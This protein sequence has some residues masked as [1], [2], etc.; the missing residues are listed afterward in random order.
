MRGLEADVSLPVVRDFINRVKERSKGAEVSGA[1]NPAQQVVKIVNDELTRT[2]GGET[3]RIAYSPKPPT[4]V[5]YKKHI[6]SLFLI[7]RETTSFLLD[8]C[9]R[10]QVSFEE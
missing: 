6:V 5:T 2:L 9:D 1:L 4:V 3:I 8:N 7:F 10:N